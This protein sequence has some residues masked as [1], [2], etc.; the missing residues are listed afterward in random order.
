MLPTNVPSS[1][2][3][4]QFNTFFMDKI[5]LLRAKLDTV[6]A[7]PEFIDSCKEVL[8]HFDPV[9]E[10][11]IRK[12]IL[13]SPK[14]SC[15][16]DPLPS[17]LFIECLD[18]L[19]PHI[20]SIINLSLQTGSVPGSFKQAIVRPL[21]KKANIDQDVLKNYR[22]VSNLNFLSKILEKVVLSQLKA[23]LV[24]NSLQEKFQSAYKQK[25]STETAL[26]KVTSDLLQASDDGKVSILA[27][28]D[29]SAAF[30]TIDHEILLTRLSIT[31][32]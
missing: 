25:H 32:I 30:D 1:E 20:T 19:L 24:K 12:I 14:K 18:V 13:G 23:H 28:L 29:L 7:K 15:E 10:D 5:D 27:L 22:P 17:K 4:D 2:L 11:V 16:L 26:I 8:D 9:S 3:P 21:L 31:Y 6:H